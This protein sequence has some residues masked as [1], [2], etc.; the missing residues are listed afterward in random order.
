[1]ARFLFASWEGGGHVQPLA[2][3]AR[4]LMDLGHEALF[5]SDAV[6][7]AD[8]EALGVKF[9]PWRRAPS[10]TDRA[11]DSDPV[12]DWRATTPLEMIER[13]TDRIICGPATLYGQD[14]VEAIADFAPDVVACHELLFGVMAAAETKKVR[15]AV[16][17]ANVWSL[18]TLDTG[19]PFGGG[20]PPPRTEF[21]FELYGRLRDATRQAFQGGLDALNAARG[22]LCLRPVGDIFHQ[23]DA[24]SRILLATSRAF[25]FDQALPPPYAYVGPYFADPEWTEA[26]TPPWPESD[27]RPLALVS[28]S[29]MYQG[30][31]AVL[32]RVIEALGTLDVRGVVTLG[33]SLR[34]EDFPAPRNVAIA[35]RAPHG[36]ILP[37]ASLVITHAGHASA[38]RPLMAGVPVVALP[39]GRDQP[40]N[41]QR[42]AERGAGV[43]LL[44][45]APADEIASALTTVL[46]D[47]RYRQA[48][49]QLGARITLD[50][51]ARSAE[52]EL[53]ALA[54]GA[55]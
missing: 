42:I 39:L 48:A 30:Q 55:S 29:T 22:A 8:C 23:L 19:P 9:R 44:P 12:Q 49:K 53:I 47:P 54:E 4:G 14:A 2:L 37:H 5:L 20:L 24:A 40:D 33:P 51:E 18:P 38:L 1:M 52:R 27:Q 32:R 11:P 17:S 46:S 34:P 7:E 43:R 28:F 41:A 45:D 3:I 15:L 16:V 6:N 35:A 10:R 31:E 36:H 26:W 13:L 21:D 25:D 50:A